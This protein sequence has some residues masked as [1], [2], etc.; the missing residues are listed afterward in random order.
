MLVFLWKMSFGHLLGDE[1]GG[2]SCNAQQFG[3]AALFY[4]KLS[5]EPPPD[6][7]MANKSLNLNMAVRL[8][9]NS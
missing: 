4:H 2:N 3:M 6:T 9:M 7:F 1:N 5:G 8:L